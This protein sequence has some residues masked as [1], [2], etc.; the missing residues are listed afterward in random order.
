MSLLNGVIEVVVN[1]NTLGTLIAG[2]KEACSLGHQPGDHK[3]LDLALS[4]M[5]M[6]SPRPREQH[7][8]EAVLEHFPNGKMPWEPERFTGH[9]FVGLAD[10]SIRPGEAKL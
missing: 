3:A 2:S 9:S 5:K 10:Q 1:L 4:D 6:G 7:P 8:S